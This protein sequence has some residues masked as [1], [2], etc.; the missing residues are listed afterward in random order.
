MKKKAIKRIK[1][2]K[3]SEV[4]KIDPELT[5]WIRGQLPSVKYL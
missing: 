3:A 2:R 5:K 4:N 1:T